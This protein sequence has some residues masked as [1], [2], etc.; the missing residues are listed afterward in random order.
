MT[1]K[2][3]KIPSLNNARSSI[4]IDA[5][6]EVPTKLYTI[7]IDKLPKSKREVGS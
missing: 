6:K 2:N 4:E 5:V 7:K 1:L 3:F